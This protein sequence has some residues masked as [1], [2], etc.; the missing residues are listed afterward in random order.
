VLIPVQVEFL[1]AKGLEL[2]SQTIM[3]VKEDLNPK[4]EFKGILYTM[5]DKR[6]NLSKTI[7][8]FIDQ[9]YGQHVNIFN[10][11]IPKSVKASEPT[12]VGK[13]AYAYDA[14]SSVSKAYEQFAKEVISH[15]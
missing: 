7:L 5:Y 15:G 14:E 10:Q 11:A 6:L 9:S 12:F 8:N 4:L 2:L 3:S 13:S 1:S